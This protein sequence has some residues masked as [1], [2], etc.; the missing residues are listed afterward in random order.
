MTPDR[1]TSMGQPKSEKLKVESNK[2]RRVSLPGPKRDNQN[3]ALF[4]I[5]EEE[6]ETE[7]TMT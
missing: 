2:Q 6:K 7:I 1:R 4:T 3:S 5:T